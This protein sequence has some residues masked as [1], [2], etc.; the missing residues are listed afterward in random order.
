MTGGVRGR[1]ETVLSG[2]RRETAAALASSRNRGRV[3]E[4]WGVE[5]EDGGEVAIGLLPLSHRS[6][7]LLPVLLDREENWHVSN[8]VKGL[9]WLPTGSQCHLVLW[10]CLLINNLKCGRTLR[11]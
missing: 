2:G 7:H 5:E 3:G 10:G 9:T 8:G 6:L 11:F 1:L 4:G